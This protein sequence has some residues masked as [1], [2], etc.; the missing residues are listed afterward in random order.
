MEVC[1]L[2]LTTQGMDHRCQLCSVTQQCQS[3]AACS[4][5]QP[6]VSRK[7]AIF[8]KLIP[9]LKIMCVR[10]LAW[11]NAWDTEGPQQMTDTSPFL[12]SQKGRV[13]T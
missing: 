10:E 7:A 9:C 4:P 13:K 11:D 3:T 12:G 2:H 5:T 1:R 6:H 8:L